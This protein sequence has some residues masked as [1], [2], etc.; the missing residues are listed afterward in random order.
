M[1][2]FKQYINKKI[3]NKIDYNVKKEKKSNEKKEATGKTEETL[4]QNEQKVEETKK[5]GNRK[6]REC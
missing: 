6:R 3:D 1:K 5:K 4:G 2:S